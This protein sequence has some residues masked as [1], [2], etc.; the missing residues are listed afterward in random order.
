MIGE[1]EGVV[2]PVIVGYSRRAALVFFVLYDK[3]TIGQVERYSEMHAIAFLDSGVFLVTIPDHLLGTAWLQ[4]NASDLLSHATVSE[5]AV[6]ST[7][8]TQLA[9]L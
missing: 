9:F 6:Q 8:S 4:T 7:R 2:L 5:S 3:A 1:G